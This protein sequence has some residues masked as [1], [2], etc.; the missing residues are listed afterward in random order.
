MRTTIDLS[1]EL[2]N[3][4]KCLLGVKTKRE[5]VNRSLEALAQQRKSERLRGKLGKMDLDLSLESLKR[6]RQDEG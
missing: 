5:A 6:M 4:V 2:V 1:E 3:E